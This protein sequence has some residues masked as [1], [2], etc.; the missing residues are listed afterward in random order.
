MWKRRVA[1]WAL[2]SRDAPGTTRRPIGVLLLD[3]KADFLH[4]KFEAEWWSDFPAPECEI[5]RDLAKDL[6]QRTAVYSGKH[7][8]EWLKHTGSPTFKL[9]ELQ[10]IKTDNLQ[11]TL[12]ELYE[13]HVPGWYRSTRTAS[14]NGHS[15]GYTS[16][17]E[18]AHCVKAI[19]RPLGGRRF[20][21]VCAAVSLA[22]G[23][24]V[25][26][27][28]LRGLRGTANGT[29][30]PMITNQVPGPVMPPIPASWARHPITL[31]ISTINLSSSPTTT[32]RR[33]TSSGRRKL[34]I[35]EQVHIR[36][37]RSPSPTLEPPLMHISSSPAQA[38]PTLTRMPS[39]PEY[40]PRRDGFR[41]VMR[42]VVTPFKYLAR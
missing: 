14:I 18:V 21:G 13:C 16:R 38:N 2:I 11:S 42:A 15:N 1:Q 9:S 25:G 26:F 27:H 35:A 19:L 6:E 28:L 31:M 20:S 33:R 40:Q 39:A 10:R 7:C 8:L 36:V 34:M 5:W 12:E 24:A 30:R 17:S 4:C 3:S 29:P 41:K 23:C 37:D 32:K 22:A